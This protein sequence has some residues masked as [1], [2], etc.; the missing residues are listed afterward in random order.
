MSTVRVREGVAVV[1]LDPETQVHV[2]LDPSRPY[3]SDDPLVVAYPWAFASD[4]GADTKA[5]STSVRLDM[6]T[7]DEQASAAP[8]TKRNR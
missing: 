3:R 2:P 6:Y 8:G 4:E 5:R 7:D 1:V